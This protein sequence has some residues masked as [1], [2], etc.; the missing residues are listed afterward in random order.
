MS[1]LQSP[2]SFHK[3]NAQGVFH[4][5]VLTPE[6]NSN[7][8]LWP[9]VTHTAWRSQLPVS[10][11]NSES[12]RYHCSNCCKKFPNPSCFLP[13]QGRKTWWNVDSPPVGS[14][15]PE[16]RPSEAVVPGPSVQ[17]SKKF[18]R[19]KKQEL[20]RMSSIISKNYFPKLQNRNAAA[21]T[22]STSNQHSSTVSPKRKHGKNCSGTLWPMCKHSRATC[23]DTCNSICGHFAC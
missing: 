4:W 7:K 6:A 16:T 2:T 10:L 13:K 9:A 11:W 20:N 3:Q 23:N 18:K 5:K 19:L 21:K 14:L 12:S 1:K 15:P 17:K 22:L 8:T